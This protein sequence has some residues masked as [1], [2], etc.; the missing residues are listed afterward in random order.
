MLLT[1]TAGH[2]YETGEFGGIS[3][4]PGGTVEIDDG[5]C[6]QGRYL[7]GSVRPSIVE[8][9]APFLLPVA[10][11]VASP[12]P[13]PAPEQTASLLEASGVPPAVA[14]LMASGNV[15]PPKRGPG[16][17]RKVVK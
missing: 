17:P 13:P 12:S 9:I 4:P 16:R 6:R 2:V 8:R 15:E 14:A 11:Q 3:V 1:N 10:G 5:Y 7:N